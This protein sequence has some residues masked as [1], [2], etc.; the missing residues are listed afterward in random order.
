ME[1]CKV[2]L[3]T[4]ASRQ[5]A[6]AS[7]FKYGLE[8]ILVPIVRYHGETDMIVSELG[9]FRELQGL[10]PFRFRV[11]VGP[12]REGARPICFSV[13]RALMTSE[14]N[15]CYVRSCTQEFTVR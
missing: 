4:L 8:G 13:A 2:T 6:V 12:G 5:R 11:S 9:A 1:G 15:L 3:T 10:S 7:I 14:T